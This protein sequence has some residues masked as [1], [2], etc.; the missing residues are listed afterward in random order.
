[1]KNLAELEKSVSNMYSHIEKNC[2]P[3]DPSKLHTFCPAEKT[4]MKITHDQSQETLVRV[5][6]GI[7]VQPHSQSTSL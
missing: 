4:G 6:E 1:V 7:D 3:A 2:P 5:V